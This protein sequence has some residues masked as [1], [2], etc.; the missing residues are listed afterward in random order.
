MKRIITITTMLLH[1]WASTFTVFYSSSSIAGSNGVLSVLDDFK[2]GRNDPRLKH[3]ERIMQIAMTLSKESLSEEE[4]TK[5]ASLYVLRLLWADSAGY[6]FN[7][8]VLDRINDFAWDRANIDGLSKYVQEY[9]ELLADLEAT[10]K[11]VNWNDNDIANFK[12]DVESKEPA[13]KSST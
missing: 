5:K 10:Y 2:A 3:W 8:Y 4:K 7:P 13:N 9:R 11:H 6:A 12:L 1:A